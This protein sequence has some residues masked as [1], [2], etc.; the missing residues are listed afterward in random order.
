MNKSTYSMGG[1]EIKGQHGR[2]IEL[3]AAGPDV[4]YIVIYD[5]RDV[6]NINVSKSDLFAALLKI[7]E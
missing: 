2:E 5:N 4:I 1:V 6:L 3:A 7:T